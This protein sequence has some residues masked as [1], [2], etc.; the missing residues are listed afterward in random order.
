M[1]LPVRSWGQTQS[2]EAGV[3]RLLCLQFGPITIAHFRSFING[4]RDVI[5]WWRDFQLADDWIMSFPLFKLFHKQ[6]LLFSRWPDT[7]CRPFK[8]D[9]SECSIQIFSSF[10][11]LF[12]S[13][14]FP[15]PLLTFL[16]FS[17]L[18]SS[19]SSYHTLLSLFNLI[20]SNP[21]SILFYLTMVEGICPSRT[22]S[23][24]RR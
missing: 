14:P 17:I 2:T 13:F 20:F 19:H 21:L 7:E 6:R 5:R 8:L 9:R 11:F 1:L 3:L 22:Y 16:Y 24:W 12:L 15:L 4:R 23:R 18:Q 10:L